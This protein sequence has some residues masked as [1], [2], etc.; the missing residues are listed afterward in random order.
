MTPEKRVAK[1][2]AIKKSMK[3]TRDRHSHMLCRTYEVKIDSSHLNEE[4]KKHLAMLFIEAKWLYNA[5]ID[6]PKE[7]RDRNAKSVAVKVGDH[8]EDRQLLHLGADMK[9]DVV[10][11]IAHSAKSLSTQK[12]NGRNVGKLKH[13]S[14]CDAV[15]LRR[16]GTTY[17]VDFANK[18]VA[19]QK[20]RNPDAASTAGGC[21]LAGELIASL[22]MPSLKFIF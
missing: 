5:S 6:L 8:F 2:A 1:N 11:Q 20:M 18:T 12:A 4:Q 15:P 10:D 13:I 16:Y 22:E 14:E 7:Q 19:I 9:Q 3:E 17:R 21:I